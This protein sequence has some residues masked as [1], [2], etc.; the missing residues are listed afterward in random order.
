MDRRNEKIDLTKFEEFKRKEIQQQQQQQQRL[1]TDLALFH[2][3]HKKNK[4]LKLTW[5]DLFFFVF[6]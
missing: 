6:F 2:Q 1:V 5:L 4:E 3:F